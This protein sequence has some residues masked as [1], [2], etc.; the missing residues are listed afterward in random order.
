MGAR[1]DKIVQAE[2]TANQADAP[3]QEESLA[4]DPVSV[5]S[6][7]LPRSEHA[8][9]HTAKS[10]SEE[11]S[12]DSVEVVRA[13]IEQTRAEMTE[14]I[15]AIK[16]QIKPSHLVAEAKE[17]IREA[18]LGRVEQVAC[19]T[20]KIARIVG[21]EVSL[22]TREIKAETNRTVG[23]MNDI[24]GGVIRRNQL[25]SALIGIGICWL[26]IGLRKMTG[27]RL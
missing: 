26:G 14:T 12:P 17:A 19:T 6:E 23:E 10:A 11:A 15:E 1:T 18:T 22:T 16:E 20:T 7:S 2:T 9:R 3:L 21:N 25:L 27:R 24:V 5:P 13:Q 4:P 8:P